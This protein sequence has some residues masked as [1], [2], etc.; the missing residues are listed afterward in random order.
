MTTDHIKLWLNNSQFIGLVVKPYTYRVNF[1]PTFFPRFSVGDMTGVDQ[2]RWRSWVQSRFD[3][4]EGQLMWSSALPTNRYAQGHLVEVG[5]ISVRPPKMSQVG[6]GT[7]PV[8][9]G[10]VGDR[11]DSVV[12]DIGTALYPQRVTIGSRQIHVNSVMPIMSN[13]FTDYYPTFVVDWSTKPSIWHW[14]TGWWYTNIQEPVAWSGGASEGYASKLTGKLQQIWQHS[15]PPTSKDDFWISDVAY[16]SPPVMTTNLP[17]PSLFIALKEHLGVH[18]MLTYGPLANTVGGVLFPTQSTMRMLSYSTIATR[19]A[20]YDEK[21][22]KSYKGTISYLNPTVTTSAEAYWEDLVPGNPNED[23]LNMREFNGRLYIGK[24]NALW[25]YDAGRLYRVEDFSSY[26]DHWNFSHMTVHRGYMYFNIKHMLFRL[27]TAGTLE[28][29]QTYP[30]GG[31]ICDA[32]SL[33]DQLYYLVREPGLH[34]S[35][36]VWVFDPETGGNFRMFNGAKVGMTNWR[37]PRSL[38]TSQGLLFIAPL[39]DTRIGPTSVTCAPIMALDP[40]TPSI[41]R[42]F[43]DYA[44]KDSW[45][46]TSMLDFGL[47][48]MMKSF[49]KLTVDYELQGQVSDYIKV[50][51]VTA[52]NQH[53]GFM[54]GTEKRGNGNIWSDG[55]LDNYLLDGDLSTGHTYDWGTG[56]NYDH[57]VCGIQSPAGAVAGAR[58][59]RDDIAGVRFIGKWTPIA[60]GE[61]GFNIDKG[62]VI[63]RLRVYAYTWLGF[64]DVSDCCDIDISYQAGAKPGDVQYVVIDVHFTIVGYALTNATL[65]TV[66]AGAVTDSKGLRNWWTLYSNGAFENWTA[67]EMV[68]IESRQPAAV[69]SLDWTYL[70]QIGGYSDPTASEAYKTRTSLSFPR[71]FVGEQLMLKFEFY[72]S[73]MTRPSIRRYEIEWMPVPTRLRTYN[74]MVP[75]AENIEQ[76][77]LII[78]SN[79][80]SV[81]ATV[82]SMAGAGIPYTCQLPWPGSHT[83]S[84][85]VSVTSPGGVVPSLRDDNVD[86]SY[87]EIPVQ[88]DE[89]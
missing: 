48:T 60:D 11:N 35:T 56:D 65:S 51:Y 42:S 26:Y 71:G 37:S 76:P 8:N 62:I 58:Q 41:Q 6:W 5:R 10:S 83:I 87:A 89:V 38:G 44:K 1:A 31:I 85:L 63:P 88:L 21:L 84:A 25:T 52:L 30:L 27:S 55:Y 20:V 77:N 73:E 67:V 15:F 78:R 4:G 34:P 80:T 70:G 2:A 82:F 16:F 57:W 79:A 49:N 46:I 7:S 29:I 74:F 43:P 22:W 45:F 81:V 39:I 66:S 32:A 61:S 68:M 86:N 18:R 40:I 14:R 75:V 13:A 33:G 72:G 19:L 47:P 3:E 36:D 17:Y 9:F 69:P 53:R 59:I 54:T 24:P 12:G 23:V 28:Q 64:Q 50:Y